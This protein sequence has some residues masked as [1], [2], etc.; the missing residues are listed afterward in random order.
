MTRCTEGAGI[1]RG[2]YLNIETNGNFDEAS[3]TLAVY[4]VVSEGCEEFNSL[5]ADDD[6]ASYNANREAEDGGERCEVRRPTFKLSETEV[7]YT[8]VPREL[9]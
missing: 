5:Y 4:V 6:F 7:A 9:G 8:A 1:S 2:G 3:G